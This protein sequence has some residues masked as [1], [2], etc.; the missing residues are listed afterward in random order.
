MKGSLVTSLIIHLNSLIDS[1]KYQDISIQQVHSAIENKTLLQFI[2][3]KCG[4]DI[5]LSVHFY[6][7]FNFESEYEN[8]MYEMYGGYAGN[9]SKKW[10]VRNQGLCLVLA[11]TNEI[12]Q[13][14]FVFNDDPNYRLE[15]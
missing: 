1:G 8:K 9:E 4:N 3:S 12:L 7:K 6:E 11:W 13:A 10:G 2:K 15:F 14:H 5:D